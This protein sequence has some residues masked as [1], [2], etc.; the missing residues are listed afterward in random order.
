MPSIKQA[1]MMARIVY[2]FTAGIG[3]KLGFDKCKVLNI[4]QGKI[5]AC[6]NIILNGTDIIEEMGSVDIYK[7]LGVIESSNIKHSEMKN[8]AMEKFKKK[9]MNVLKSQLNSKNI[10]TAINEY[11]TPVLSYTFGIVNWTEQDIKDADILVRK[12]LNMCRMFEIRSDVDRLYIPRKMG[13]RGLVSVWDSFKT[14]HIRLAHFMIRNPNIK[15]QKC[16]E[17]DKTCLFS[18]TK[19]A[20]KF[21]DH[22]TIDLP[23]NF[24][25]QPL[26]R[27][28]QIISEKA[29]YAIQKLRYDM[30]LDKPQ[31]GIFFK[32]LEGPTVS[33]KLSISWLE[34]AH[35]APQSESYLMAAQELALFTRWHERHILKKQ[36][37]DK[38]RVCHT[39]PE[40]M[41]HIL[42]G[43]DILAKKEYLE[44]HN[45]VAQYIHHA[46]CNNLQIHTCSKWHTHKPPEVVTLKNVEILWDTP[47]STERPYVFNRPDIVVRDKQ[48]KKCYISCPNDINV[49]QKEQEKI[50]KYSGLRME[51]G[52]M[53][54]CECVVIPI[55]ISGLGVVSME[56]EKYINSLPADISTVLCIKIAL[57]GSEKILRNFLS[58]K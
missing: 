48:N 12:K 9:L 26:L 58:R 25:N 21:T 49:T 39:K 16:F 37:D 5:K 11:V 54:D 6:G 2:E 43:C 27:Q 45:G 38:C 4:V 40:T 41:S 30:C 24:D 28:A 20:E 31:H 3:M 36:V 29:K 10:M 52:R 44:R 1:E 56:F 14:T 18:I 53:W 51:L 47:I 17:F 8:F 22:L 35:M 19:R 7:Y 42:S 46:I 57:L 34:K 23:N 32:L 13:G 50:T 55:V 33:R 15:L